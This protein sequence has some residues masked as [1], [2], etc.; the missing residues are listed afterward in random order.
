MDVKLQPAPPS[1]HAAAAALNNAG[2]ALAGR[3]KTDEAIARFREA[4]EN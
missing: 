2:V 1:N 4:R 3:G